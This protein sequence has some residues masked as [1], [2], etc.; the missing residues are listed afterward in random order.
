MS[1]CID[2]GVATTAGAIESVAVVHARV[3]KALLE[4]IRLVLRKKVVDKKIQCIAS[5]TGLRKRLNEQFKGTQVTAGLSGEMLGVDYGAGG[6]L[7]SK[8]TH[9]KRHHKGMKRKSKVAWWRSVGGAHCHQV[10]RG[11]LVASSK[12]GSIVHGIAPKRMNDLRRAQAA[13][14]RVKAGGSSLTARLAIGGAN[15]ED[16]DPAVYLGSAALHAVCAKLWDELAA[17]FP[18]IKGWLQA[19]RELAA[20]HPS[21]THKFIRGPIGAA[22]AYLAEV[23]AEWHAPFRIGLLNQVINVLEV[24]PL[25]IRRILREHVR[26]ELDRRLIEK[27]IRDE[28]LPR[29]SVVSAYKHG[30][31]WSLIRD[32]LRGK[33]NPMIPST[34]WALQLLVTDAF[35]SDEKR[36]I[37]GYRGMGTCS[38]CFLEVGTRAHKLQQCQAMNIDLA[39]EEV[40]G[41]HKVNHQLMEDPS[42]GPL[43][44]RGLPPKARGWQAVEVELTKGNLAKFVAGDT[45]GDGSGIK[46]SIPHDGVATWACARINYHH[47][48]RNA[49]TTEVVAGNVPGWFQTVPRAE[50]TAYIKFLDAA[51]I[52]ACYVGDCQNVIDVARLGVPV[53]FTSSA[54]LHAD[55]WREARRLLQDHGPGI[56]HVKTKAHRSRACAEI[57]V[58]DPLHHWLGNAAADEAAKQLARETYDYTRRAA[59]DV[60]RENAAAIMG[61]SAFA[62]AWAIKNEPQAAKRTRRSSHRWGSHA[63]PEG[64]PHSLEAIGKE[65]GW[66]CSDCRLFARTAASMR[67][68][69]QKPCRG[70]IAQQ[71][72]PSHELDA[73]PGFTWCRACGAFTVRMPRALARPCPRGPRSAA[74]ANVLRRLRRGLPPTTAAYA[75]RAVERAVRDDDD[76]IWEAARHGGLNARQACR[77]VSGL[78]AEPPLELQPGGAAE[79]TDDAEARND[80]A[81]ARS[82][83]RRPVA[84]ISRGGRS[85]MTCNGVSVKDHTRGSTM[86]TGEAVKKKNQPRRRRHKKEHH[87]ADQPAV[88]QQLLHDARNDGDED[89]FTHGDNYL[90]NKWHTDAVESQPQAAPEAG[91]P[92]ARPTE[93]TAPFLAPLS[94]VAATAAPDHP[95]ARRQPCPTEDISNAATEAPIASPRSAQMVLSTAADMEA[96]GGPSPA[97]VGSRSTSLALCSRTASGIGES[98]NNAAGMVGQH[99]RATASSNTGASDHDL[100]QSADHDPSSHFGPREKAK[101]AH[102]RKESGA[103]RARNAVATIGRRPDPAASCTPGNRVCDAQPAL[104]WTKRI[105]VGIK[106]TASDCTSCGTGSTARCRFCSGALC[107]KCARSGNKCWQ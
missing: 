66:R 1:F 12:Y 33:A 98:L 2:D 23:G 30:I 3:T 43:V 27:V 19:R 45:Y 37:W 90:H 32:V 26:V 74:Q 48:T 25:Q 81:H 104:H 18:Y 17:R 22:W 69:R 41:R 55:L 31:D 42:L 9:R 53:E 4:F 57:D 49:I 99:G 96:E 39:M 44:L 40:A 85:L 97:G 11:G 21:S 52:P 16:I 76:A 93:P 71:C 50:M 13:A 5:S 10:V 14:G 58:E 94:L 84:K 95:R 62:V 65:G 20:T 79:L 89:L 56:S 73:T 70:S 105:T 91:N 75:E 24:P 6:R 51:V 7:M 47:S 36:L 107:L 60:H 61:R 54:S 80:E 100:Q 83:T 106:W 101:K 82:D 78:P 28:A 68:L 72:H 29:D 67:S 63:A 34:K 86:Q 87:D 77:V 15:F 103:S 92:G 102:S 8:P 38:G 64:G 35:W 59:D 46:S 88:A